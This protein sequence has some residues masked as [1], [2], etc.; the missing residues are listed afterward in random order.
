MKDSTKF[1]GIGLW[2]LSRLINSRKN[3]GLFGDIEE[4]YHIVLKEKGRLKAKLWLWMQ[5]LRTIPRAIYNWLYWSFVMFTN[6][7]KVTVRNFLRQ[8]LFSFI[9]LLGLAVGM[10]CCILIISYV[11]FELSYDKFHDKADRIYRLT[12]DGNLSNRPFNLAT[13]NGAIAP[14]L[15][16]T[17]PEVEDVVRF[18]RKYRSSVA[19]MDKL[20]SGMKINSLFPA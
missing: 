20:T 7:Y 12:M 15:R 8:K 2:L 14:S 17:L 4:M 9:N 1:S 3:Y 13:S 10:A 18:R 6:S 19:N 5:I 16:D 11:H